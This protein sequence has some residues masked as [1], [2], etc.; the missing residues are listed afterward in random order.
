MFGHLPTVNGCVVAQVVASGLPNH[1]DCTVHDVASVFKKMVGGLPG[2]LLGSTSLFQALRSIVVVEG[3]QPD[4]TQ[5]ARLV[6][7]ALRCVDSRWRMSIICA[8]IGLVARIGEET[9]SAVASGRAP[10]DA[11]SYQALGVVLGPTLL[12]ES[13]EEIDPISNNTRPYTAKFPTTLQT[14]G[15][16]INAA[17]RL[18]EKLLPL[19]PDVVVQLSDIN[20]PNVKRI[21][22]SIDPEEDLPPTVARP[23]HLRVIQD[24]V[25]QGSPTTYG[26]NSS[27]KSTLIPKPQKDFDR[28]RKATSLSPSPAKTHQLDYLGEGMWFT[29]ANVDAPEEWLVEQTDETYA[30]ADSTYK[31][32]P[33]STKSQNVRQGTSPLSLGGLI[34]L[35]RLDASGAYGETTGARDVGG[36]YSKKQELPL[37]QYLKSSVRN[38][39]VS[40]S[41]Q[42]FSGAL[43]SN[44]LPLQ[45]AVWESAI[46]SSDNATL[47]EQVRML[48]RVNG[49][50]EAELAA[51]RRCMQAMRDDE[52]GKEARERKELEDGLVQNEEWRSEVKRLEAASRVGRH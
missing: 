27:K 11:M 7:L 35:S 9:A 22:E 36:E 28:G 12:G 29:D 15:A 14:Y 3:G 39:T 20:K 47:F 25:L 45:P 34:I 8:T 18:L 37:R 32:R 10:Q 5:K 52:G 49:A 13:I 2:G 30:A 24:D 31:K 4:S 48:R 44:L 38:N 17:A 50:Q 51:I 40:K 46:R 1:I 43:H 23:N 16:Q 21:V 41:T 42:T 26:E 6:A 19:W 33:M